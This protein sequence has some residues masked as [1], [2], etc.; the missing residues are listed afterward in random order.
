[1]S[2]SS[3]LKRVP[4]LGYQFVEFVLHP[5]LYSVGWKGHADERVPSK[6]VLG[7]CVAASFLLFATYRLAFGSLPDN[8]LNAFGISIPPASKDLTL[9]TSRPRI[10]HISWQFVSAPRSHLAFG[11]SVLCWSAELPDPWQQIPDLAGRC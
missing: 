1:M 8:L 2:L 7:W 4:A 3:V 11:R 6:E 5:R 10:E 9:K